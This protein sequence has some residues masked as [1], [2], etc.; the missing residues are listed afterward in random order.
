MSRARPA[1]RRRPRRGP[2]ADPAAA[3]REPAPR[4]RLPRRRGLPRPAPAGR[5]AAP[6]AGRSTSGRRPW[7]RAVASSTSPPPSVSG[8]ERRRTTTRSPSAASSGRSRRSC[9]RSSPRCGEARRGCRAC[10]GGPGR[11]R[12]DARRRAASSAQSRIVVSATRPVR[13]STS[14]RDDLAAAHAREVHGDPLA[15]ARLR[16]PARRGPGAPRTRTGAL[17]G[18]QRER[19]AV[20]Q[21]R[22]TTACP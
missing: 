5:R 2:A 19:V 1:S 15:G 17:A 4:R 14:P 9:Q 22:R 12:R 11:A 16:R 18:Q 20:A 6:A 7:R 8:G 10:R 3:G 13:A 21:R